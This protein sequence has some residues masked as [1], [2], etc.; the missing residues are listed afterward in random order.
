MLLLSDDVEKVQ[1]TRG[2]GSGSIDL[3][4]FEG[5]KNGSVG[6]KVRLE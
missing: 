2:R 6:G 4:F 1:L 3:P 5:E